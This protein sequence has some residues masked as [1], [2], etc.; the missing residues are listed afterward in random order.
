MHD[1]DR[2]QRRL[3]LSHASEDKPDVQRLR[4]ALA[5]R[6]IGAWEDVLEL[7]LGGKLDQLRDAIVTADGLVLLLTPASIGS[8]WVQREVAWAREAQ[9]LSPDFVILP[10]LR[11]LKR[12]ALK[13][14]LG[15]E[16]RLSILLADGDP[17]EGAVPA[18]VQALG[19]A[20][21]D[22]TPR[23]DPSPAPPMAELVIQL[24]KPRVHEEAGTSRAAAEAEVLYRPAGGGRGI[25]GPP[26]DFV[27]P[28]GP[29]EANELRWY[30]EA[31]GIWPFGT[32]KDRAAAVE[33]DLPRWGRRLFD[34]TL[35]RPEALR[36]FEAWRNAAGVERRVTVLVDD[37][38]G[39]PETQ[40]A[41]KKAAAMLLALPW[42]ILAD[43]AGHYLFEGLRARV[44]RALP[45]ADALPPVAPRVP[46]RILL[47]LARPDDPR[48]AFLDPRVSALP[49]SEALDPLG[50]SV[51]LTVLADGTLGALREALDA[52]EKA[53]RPFQVVH[54]DGHGVYDERLGL[55]QLCFENAADAAEGKL[56]RGVEMVDAAVLGGLLAERRV[57][58]F[59]LEACQTAM[60]DR[61][62]TAS[63]AAT[64]LEV[65]VASVVAMSH[66]VYVETA[67]RFVGAFYRALAEGDR[68]GAAMVRAQH[69]LKDDRAR[70]EMRGTPFLMSDWMVP[71]LF[72]ESADVPLL[73][74]GIDFRPASVEDRKRVAKVK[75]GDLP[76]PPAHGFVGRAKA[77]L[78][79]DR[80]LARNAVVA[81]VGGGGQGKTALAVEAARWLLAMR[82]VDRVAFVSV[83]KVSEAR[84][85]LDAIGR[86]L[87]VGYSVA[88][89]EGTGSEE[90]KRRRALLP[91]EGVLQARRVL[92]V[93]DNLES[94]LPA[95]GEE[96]DEGA[97]GAAGDAA[98]D[99]RGGEDAG[100]ADE[101]G[102]AA[103]GG[104]KVFGMP[105]LGKGEG[106]A[107]LAGVFK[108]NGLEPRKAKED[109]E[110]VED[111]VDAVGGHARSLVLLGELVA[112]YGVEVVAK[113]VR[114]MMGELE[115]R[116][117]D[118]RE[119]SLIAS[120]RLSLRRLPQGVRDKIR[121]LAVFQGAAHVG[122]MA[123]VLEVEPKEARELC[124][125]VVGVGL[126]DADGP[127]LLPDPGLGAALA[128][129][130]TD[131]ER[132]AAEGRWIEATMRL[133]R[134]LYEQRG[135]DAKV[136]FRGTR[137]ALTELMSGLAEL[138]REVAAGRAD[139]ADAIGYATQLEALVSS[140]GLPR[141]L[142]RIGGV[143]RELMGRLPAWNHARVIAESEEVERKNE[144]GD[145]VGA[146]DVA[147][148]LRDRAE[149]AG[150]AYS[151]AAYDRAMAWLRLG[152]MLEASGNSEEALSVLEEA[153]ERF[154]TLARAGSQAA[155]AMEVLAIA[156]KGDTLCGL[157][158]LDEAAA[159][160]ED[161]IQRATVL[162]DT[163]QIAVGESQLGL[164][165]LNQ[166]RL[167][168]ALAAF[169]KGRVTFEELGEPAPAATAW[170]QIG[171]VHEEGENFKAAEHAY[172][173]SMALRTAQG[174][175]A[176]EALTLRQLGRLYL[177][178]DR[179]ED[180]AAIY[181]QAVDI[182]RSLG[183]RLEEGKCLADF[184]LV[185]RRLR[186]FD[187]AREVL[188]SAL[189]LKK[190]YGH[191][192]LP[193]STWATLEN[194][195]RD[196]GRPT[197][198]L[199]ARRQAMRTYRA[200]RADGGEPMYDSTRF[201]D[202][203]GRTL[204]TSG[205]DA[206]RA[207]LARLAEVHD[208]FA[209]TIR[210]LQA[211]AAG[212]RDPALADDPTL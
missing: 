104:G 1:H 48:A 107:L 40:P 54:F 150:N 68:I 149:A 134:F 65:G 205:P 21:Q 195:E 52:A 42:E 18:I 10:I 95:V 188:T 50:E 175:R 62:P 192:A 110:A 136:A 203:F 51:S 46:L 152:G 132:E 143:R 2:I 53:G 39:P 122:V 72:Q 6:G 70:G 161:V 199:E 118:Q 3:F 90:E 117:P 151:G 115:K 170:H 201:I 84:A 38:G 142:A 159:H 80:L 97:R 210:A 146:L 174:D 198:A 55:G 103:G 23:A 34:A 35:G 145:V 109:R 8:D 86:Q 169:E 114:G 22:A 19:L 189:A 147:R 73:P 16:E 164:V 158:R 111:L 9:A 184:G 36:A 12:P 66:S 179:L 176:G 57:P 30:L 130:L 81:L 141:V 27:A 180:A 171:V 211:I 116:W 87:V 112:E 100:A 88:E 13:L 167:V 14:L 56:E 45:S 137:V 24:K 76:E 127:Y 37:R 71:V 154:S 101:P 194:V 128:G 153:R 186:R 59:V 26:A 4:I 125:R 28:L 44:R 135:Q 92:I 144:A 190:L 82:R 121:G 78:A 120:V 58:L 193:W 157:G 207:L 133:V 49:L 183:N 67:R 29:I 131:E 47:V 91:V 83:E 11:G 173:T 17:I 43:P 63:V 31:Y 202:A 160:H 75:R 197:A 163:R 7:R 209:P 126:A 148:R 64:L 182:T 106:L 206:A 168:E 139:A 69:V 208:W 74:A 124:G 123:R 32:F 177:R 187:E 166:G 108:A 25:E 155:A 20:P 89:A 96:V 212:S 162:G 185:L 99:G 200:Y 119:R 196:A 113:D 156:D 129:E 98:G 191:A 33:A 105:A 181:R 77:L 102:G 85:V 93:V 94:V 79:I 61:S 204:R 15:G 138:E 140:L 60:T 172:K 165:R 5:D 41:R 178:Q